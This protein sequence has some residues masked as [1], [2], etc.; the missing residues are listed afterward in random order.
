MCS[1]LRFLKRV[2]F[3]ISLMVSPIIQQLVNA[4]TVGSLYALIALGYTM[5]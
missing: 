4:L 2:F 5:V 3:D 1:R